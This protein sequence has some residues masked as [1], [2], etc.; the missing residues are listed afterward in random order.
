MG[1]EGRDYYR[2]GQRYTDRLA[3]W[4]WQSIPTACKWIILINVVVYI[5][6]FLVT[7][8]AP[9]PNLREM[10]PDDMSRQLTD[11]QLRELPMMYSVHKVSVVQEWLQLDTSKVLHGQFWRL[12][13]YAFCHDTS[14]VMHIVLNM[15]FF[16]WLGPTLE[17][18]YGS[19]EFSLFYAC[20]AMVAALAYMGLNLLTGRALP[21][22]GASGA[23]MAVTMLYAIYYP[24]TVIYVMF[25]IPVE[26][27]WLVVAY[28][29]FDLHP[30]LLELAQQRVFTGVAH[31]A[32]LGGLAFGLAYWRFDIRLSPLVPG[33]S[34]PRFDRLVGPRRRLRVYDPQPEPDEVPA[35]SDA[36]VDEI[37]KKIHERGEASLT[38]KERQILV[39]ASRRYQNRN[40]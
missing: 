9:A 11:E 1:I 39:A 24:R 33:F 31:A 15:L 2:E 36:E 37:L 14:N 29:I 20:S 32:H 22:I 18:M 21:M 28:V 3:G 30:V 16:F 12:V 34:R 10:L 13:T 23:V 27:R 19:R 35:A 40:R 8:S 25:F 26:I 7:R 5:L 4:G 6:Q 38:H 17:S